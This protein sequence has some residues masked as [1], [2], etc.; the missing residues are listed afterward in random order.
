MT[1][2]LK[3]LLLLV[4][5]FACG[6]LSAAEE[7]FSS[8]EEQMTGKEFSEAGLDRLSQAELDALNG[9]IRRHSLATLATP[10]SAS[11]SASASGSASTAAAAAA[12]ED[13]AEDRRGFKDFEGD[14]TPITSRIVGNFSGWDG[15][16]VFELENG[17]I[18]AQSDK[19]KFYVKELEN[20]VAVIEPG[21]FGSWKLHIEGHDSECRVE[22]LE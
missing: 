17:M 14:R 20:P 16:T 5:C 8:L 9:W 4:G 19:D 2:T 1:R 11:A 12:V 3:P 15:Q 13:S 6:V 10:A 21:L 7:G 22:R 18:W